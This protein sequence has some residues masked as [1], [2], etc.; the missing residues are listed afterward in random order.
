[1]DVFQRFLRGAGR[2]RVCGHDADDGIGD[3][4]SAAHDRA[5][6]HGVGTDHER[7]TFDDRGAQF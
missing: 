6:H 1:V 5:A 3:D 4:G 2:H 7:L